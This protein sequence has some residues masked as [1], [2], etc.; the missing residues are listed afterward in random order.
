[1]SSCCAACCRAEP[2]GARQAAIAVSRRRDTGRASAKPARLIAGGGGRLGNERRPPSTELTVNSSLGT[3]LPASA[4]FWTGA[5]PFLYK[6]AAAS[7]Q[8]AQLVEQRTE[9]PC[10]GS[11]ILPLGTS[12]F[13]GLD[14]QRPPPGGFCVSHAV[15][16]KAVHFRHLPRCT[17]N[18]MRQA[19]TRIDRRGA[20]LL[21]SHRSG[22]ITRL[23]RRGSQR[24]A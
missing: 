16:R 6:S 1:M 2:T 21:R 18:S 23:S 15:L 11:S 14:T 3:G 13:S 17:G 9:N 24:M 8:V 7:A 19:T 12:L 5:A 10:V 20:R 4:E 22:T